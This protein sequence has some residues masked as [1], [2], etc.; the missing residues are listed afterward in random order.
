MH[1][2]KTQRAPCSPELAEQHR[3]APTP[4]ATVF[5]VDDDPSIQRS[6]LRLLHAGGY[7][8]EAFGSCR[9]F[10]DRRTALLAA[11]ATG[12]NAPTAECLVLDICMPAMGGLS[13]QEELTRRNDILPIVF[14]TGHG[15][16]P[17]SVQAMKKG[18]VDF[19]SKPFDQKDLQQAIHA[20]MAKSRALRQVHHAQ[21]AATR[22]LKTLTTRER[23]VLDRVVTGALNKQIAMDL[24]ISEPTVKV[25]RGH[26]MEKMGVASVA[27]LVRIVDC[28]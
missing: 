21:Q 6:L 4:P 25:H 18:A 22:R 2:P 27:E 24:G 28:A 10:L 5:I 15:D 1:K 26:V 13:L 14:I 16:V 23:E 11:C 9:E 20:A 3:T 7:K 17:T 12:D 19:L 8:A